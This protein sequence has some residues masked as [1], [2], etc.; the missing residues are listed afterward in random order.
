MAAADNNKRKRFAWDPSNC[1]QKDSGTSPC[2]TC[3]R[4]RADKLLEGSK[5]IHESLTSIEEQTQQVA[6]TS[7]NVSDH[8][9]EIVKQSEAEAFEQKQSSMFV[10]L[11][12]LFALQDA[13]LVETRSMKAVVFYFISMLAIYM[14]T[15]T[16]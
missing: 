14:L 12:R 2:P 15:S 4:K 13:L 7:K 16:K 6:Q 11:D 1:F 9:G 8:I 10:A 5:V 3:R